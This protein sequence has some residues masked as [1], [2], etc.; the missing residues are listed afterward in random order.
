LRVLRVWVVRVL[1]VVRVVRVV[2]LVLV[3]RIV[4]VSVQFPVAALA[5]SQDGGRRRASAQIAVQF[6]FGFERSGE[7]GNRL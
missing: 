4:A 1:R 5:R 6:R 7:C 2:R 3:V